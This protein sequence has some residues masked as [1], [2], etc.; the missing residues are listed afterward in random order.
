MLFLNY[1]CSFISPNGSF[2]TVFFKNNVIKNSTILRVSDPS[3][4]LTRRGGHTKTETLNQTIS[5]IKTKF[6]GKTI[7]NAWFLE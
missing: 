6:P 5:R 3:S 7:D 2:Q 1:D 4:I